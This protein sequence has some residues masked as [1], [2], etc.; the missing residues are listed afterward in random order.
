[1]TIYELELIQSD[2]KMT[3]LF[4]KVKKAF[5]AGYEKLDTCDEVYINEYHDLDGK[6]VKTGFPTKLGK[7][8]K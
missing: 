5:K 1:M 3:I 4:S 8:Q 6:F 2:S 7:P